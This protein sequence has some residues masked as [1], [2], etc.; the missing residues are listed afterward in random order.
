MPTFTR[1]LIVL[2]FRRLESDGM[3]RSMNLQELFG[4]KKGVLVGVPGAFT[5]TCSKVHLPEFVD[6][7]S[8][9]AAKVTSGRFVT[10]LV[11]S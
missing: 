10:C 2:C 5:P 6:K 9:L 3:V 1:S 8:R 7:A 4:K 11:L